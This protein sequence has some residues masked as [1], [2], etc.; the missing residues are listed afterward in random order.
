[1]YWDQP[2]GSFTDLNLSDEASEAK[3]RILQNIIIAAK[4]VKI[5]HMVVVDDGSLLQLLKTSGVPYTCIV[6]P[7]L[8]DTPN[9]TF[10]GGLCDDLTI[11]PVNEARNDSDSSV[12]REDLAALCVQS[13]LTMSWEQSRCLA[14]SS[15]GPLRLPVATEPYKRVDQQWCVNSFILQSKLEEAINRDLLTTDVRS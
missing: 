5:Q 8:M 7:K 14:V 12:C 10:K 15:N 2:K 13:L 6:A 3:L 4:E 9:Y 1:M 11:L